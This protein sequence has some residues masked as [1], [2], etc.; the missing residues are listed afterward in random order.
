MA[1]AEVPPTPNQSSAVGADLDYHRIKTPKLT[2]RLHNTSW[3]HSQS[4]GEN[5][6]NLPDWLSDRERT[7]VVRSVPKLK[8]HEEEFAQSPRTVAYVNCLLQN[9]NKIC[10]NSPKIPT[11]SV[12][13]LEVGFSIENI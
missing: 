10:R 8:L 12:K 5:E 9:H 4:Y 1:S 13:K 3:S 7:T 11:T 2:G 6:I